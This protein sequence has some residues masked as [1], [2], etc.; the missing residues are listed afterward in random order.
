[1]ND[2]KTQLNTLKA[3][4]KEL[5]KIGNLQEYFLVIKKANSIEQ[6]LQLVK[7]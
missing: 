7:I 6:Q 1:M 3:L 2:L 4:A 5:M